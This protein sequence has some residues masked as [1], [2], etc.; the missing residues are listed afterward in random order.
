MIVREV[1][2]YDP[3]RFDALMDWPLR[4]LFLAFIERLKRQARRSYEVDVLVW[5]VLA[6]YQKR[7]TKPPGLPAILR[8]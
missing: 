7:Q 5:A 1:A 3:A 4:D 6:P 8:S 2:E